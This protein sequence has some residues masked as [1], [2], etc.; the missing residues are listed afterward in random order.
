[1]G[2][3]DGTR[4]YARDQRVK[5]RCYKICRADGSIY[6]KAQKITAFGKTT[7]AW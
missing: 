4:N 3:A 2:R 5:T 1:M 7:I 6:Q